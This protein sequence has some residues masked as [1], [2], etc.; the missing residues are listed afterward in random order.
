MSLSTEP[1]PVPIQI[2]AH[3]VARVGGTRVTLESVMGVFKQGSSPEEI[4]S[5]FPTLKLADVYAVLTFY[6][7]NREQVEQYLDEAER[8]GEAIR[9]EI[10]AH[11]PENIGLRERLLAR[12]RLME[13]GDAPPFR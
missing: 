10:E 3:G 9:R 8:Q 2:D 4:V 1:L 6:L 11:Y 5:S 7:K 12:R 13:N